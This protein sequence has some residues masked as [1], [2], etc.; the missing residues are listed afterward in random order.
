M[1][2]LYNN[3]FELVMGTFAVLAVF[4][5]TTALYCGY[6]RDQEANEFAENNGCFVIGKLTND[7]HKYIMTCKEGLIIRRFP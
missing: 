6:L 2:W 3:A 4:L 7:N 1:K 5:L